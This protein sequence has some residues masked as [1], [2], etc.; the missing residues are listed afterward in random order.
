[1]ETGPKDYSIAGTNA[2]KAFNALGSLGTMAFAYNTVILPE[3][4][5]TTAHLALQMSRS[6]VR[7]LPEAFG[8]CMVMV[9][10]HWSNAVM[11]R[12]SYIDVLNGHSPLQ[13]MA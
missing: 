5:V 8:V 9:I 13:C 3:I 4:Q 11:C 10:V 2:D 7:I 6:E 1:M 12:M